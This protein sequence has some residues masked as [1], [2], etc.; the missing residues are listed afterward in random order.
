M[1]DFET[2]LNNL[3]SRETEPLPRY[4]FART[5]EMAALGQDLLE[6]LQKKQAD[7]SLQVE[8]IYDLLKEQNTQVLQDALEAEKSRADTLAYTAIALCD[9]LEDFCA[10]ARLSGN[11][12]LK[13]Q[14]DLLWTQSGQLLS[15]NNIVRVGTE[16]Q[17]LNPQIHTVQK[18]VESWLPREQVL[19]VLQSGYVYKNALVRKAAVVVSVGPVGFSGTNGSQ[20]QGDM[21]NREW[22]EKDGE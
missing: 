4:E 3:L 18:G 10:Y 6:D 17:P 1:L 12:E 14:A 16:G 9:L 20:E 2:E 13:H 8:E 15:D 19:E 21:T 22:E 7:V 11:E 5:V